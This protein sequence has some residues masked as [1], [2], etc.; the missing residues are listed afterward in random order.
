MIHLE[1][2]NRPSVE[3]ITRQFSKN[4]NKIFAWSKVL[5]LYLFIFNV[6]KCI[7][8]T[9]DWKKDAKNSKNGEFEE[10]LLNINEQIPQV[11]KEGSSEK[12]NIIMEKYLKKFVLKDDCF[13]LTYL[14]E[15]LKNKNEK[16]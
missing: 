10:E 14:V 4:S 11:V 15:D 5:I 12:E 3:K 6:F 1:P 16:K 13:A 8:P 2:S 7:L 9:Y